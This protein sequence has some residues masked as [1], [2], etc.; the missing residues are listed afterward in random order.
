M[1]RERGLKQ[2]WVAK[3]IGIHPVA[4]S[5]ILD[6]KYPFPKDKITPL[7][8]TLR[9]PSRDIREALPRDVSP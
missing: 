2:T 3:E 1:I 7:A 6:G 9:L 5:R 8:K 4:F